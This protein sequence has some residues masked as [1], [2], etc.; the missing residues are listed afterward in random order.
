MEYIITASASII[1][2]LL[3]A[4]FTRHLE[5]MKQRRERLAEAYAAF[6]VTIYQNFPRFSET[7]I[8]EILIAAERLKLFCSPESVEL[9]NKILFELA[10]SPANQEE[11]AILAGL[12][13]IS[14]RKELR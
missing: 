8:S 5:L 12:L 3:T 11:I 6:F 13:R 2:V 1:A 14:G 9:I 4:L 7:K 10:K